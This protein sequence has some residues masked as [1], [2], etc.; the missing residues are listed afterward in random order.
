[1]E[2]LGHHMDAQGIDTSKKKV[3]IDKEALSVVFGT[4][5]FHTYPYGHRFTFV[6][7]HKPLRSILGTKRGLPPLAAARM[8]FWAVTL[9][10]YSYD[11]RF[12]TT[13]EPANADC[14]LRL[15]RLD[16]Q[17]VG[18]PED[19]TIVDAVQLQALPVQALAVEAHTRLDLILSRVLIYLKKGWP[20]E[21]PVDL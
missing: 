3:Q 6:T 21:V 7:D 20:E 18:K 12:R 17:K 4:K 19:P 10:S 11:I 15:P 1:M 2:Y 16:K 14:L 5:K 13:K 9:S 8:Q